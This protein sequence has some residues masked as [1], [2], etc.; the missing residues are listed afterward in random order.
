LAGLAA[1]YRGR[2]KLVPLSYGTVRDFCDS[3]DQL[4]PIATAN[5]DLKDNQRPWALKAI[6]SVV[7][8]GGRVLEIGAGEPFIADILDRLGYEVWV[9]DPYDGTGNGPLEYER[10]QKECPRVHFVRGYFCE[11]VLPAPPA[12]FDCIYSI[13]V[14]EH[15]S[16]KLLEGV[17]AGLKKYLRPNGWSIHAVDHIHRGNGAVEHCEK[18]RSI[19]RG[20]G[21]EENTLTQLVERMN[22][23]PETYFLSAESHNRWRGGLSYDEFP[24]RVC[25]SIQLVSQAANVHGP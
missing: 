22:E 10:F 20:S 2:F 16:V 1:K 24:M 5:G 12:G 6:L 14:L 19:V 7:P 3:F 11:H 9:V 15:V 17:F 4:H 23:D 18:L 21:L 13:S 8:P 25:V